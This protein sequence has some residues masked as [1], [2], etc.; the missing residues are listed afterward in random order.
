MAQL[1]RASLASGVFELELLDFKRLDAGGQ[2]AMRIVVCL[3]EAFASQLDGPCTYGNA[4]IA[5]GRLGPQLEA[6]AH[7]KEEE[8]QEEEE[9]ARVTRRRTT[10]GFVVPPVQTVRAASPLLGQPAGEQQHE[11]GAFLSIGEALAATAAHSAEQQPGSA[12]NRSAAS[13]SSVVVRHGAH[14][15]QQQQ[16]QQGSLMTNAVRIQFTFRWPVSNFL[17]RRLSLASKFEV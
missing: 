15:H 8:Q 9:E 7:E 3:K 13:S 11:R 12:G 17:S 16:Q 4:S 14:K 6:T 2:Q 5:L 10:S 1:P